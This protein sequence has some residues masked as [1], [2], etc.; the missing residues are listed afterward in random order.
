MSQLAVDQDPSSYVEIRRTWTDD[1][2]HIVFPKSLVAVPLPDDEEMVGFMD[3]PVVLAGLNPGEQ[4]TAAQTKATGDKN[5]RP[6][7]RI[8]GLTLR[9]DPTLP[10]SIL[11]P[12]NE[13]EWTYWR[14]DYRTRGQVQD[15]RFIPLY[16]IRDEVFTVYFGVHNS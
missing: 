3:G 4:P 16:E 14:T 11:T 8:S 12:D 7:Y 6:N 9:G 10:Q 15:I 2:I 13:R 5:A 1:G